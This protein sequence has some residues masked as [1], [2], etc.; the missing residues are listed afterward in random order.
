MKEDNVRASEKPAK[1]H[2]RLS[3]NPKPIKN[4]ILKP[5]VK[6][7]SSIES[8]FN[9]N[10]RIKTKPGTKVRYKKPST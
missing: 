7:N 2:N 9:F 1:G 6:S 10:K 4:A 3:N 5:T 8:S